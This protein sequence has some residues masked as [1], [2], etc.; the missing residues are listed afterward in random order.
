MGNTKARLPILVVDSLCPFLYQTRTLRTYT[1]Q[2]SNRISSQPAGPEEVASNES[3]QKVGDGRS[4]PY[5]P[6]FLQQKAAETGQ[7]PKGPVGSSL[8]STLTPAERKAFQNLI[9]KFGLPAGADA[10]ITSRKLSGAEQRAASESADNPINQETMHALLQANYDT[11]IDTILSLFAPDTPEMALERQDAIAVSDNKSSP[12]DEDRHRPYPAYKIRDAA[13]NALK[14]VFE[15]FRITLASSVNPT[16]AHLLNPKPTEALLWQTIT[17]QVFA[18]IEVLRSLNSANPSYQRATLSDIEATD[19]VPPCLKSLSQDVPL[20]PLLTILYPASTLLALQ[21]YIRYL[22]TSPCAIALLPHIK[23]LGPISY[24]LASNVHFYNALLHLQWTVY[25]DFSAIMTLLAE[26]E[27][28]G[29]ER[30]KGTAAV[31][32]SIRLDRTRDLELENA[33]DKE[34]SKAHT[35]RPKSWWKSQAQIQGFQAIYEVSRPRL[36]QKFRQR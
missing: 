32:E 4:L 22:P 23:S 8:G 17:S 11:N 21:T 31:L 5:R 13:R 33:K 9:S 34:S 29:V 16:R 25:S 24:L 19:I 27:Q 2:R 12:S 28:N 1:T 26:M 18:Q 15:S 35:G 7:V 6:T 20:I 10:L 3:Q 30:N 14:D 36:Q